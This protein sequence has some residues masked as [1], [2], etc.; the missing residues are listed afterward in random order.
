MRLPR[1]PAPFL[2]LGAFLFAGDLKGG[3]LLSRIPVDLTLLTGA[4]LAAVLA[5]RWM[6]GRSAAAAGPGPVLEALWYSTFLPGV[7]EAPDTPYAL[8]KMA[9]LF[10]FSLLALLAPL[11]LVRGEEDLAG[12]LDAMALFALALVLDGFLAAGEGWQ[13]LASAGG[14][15]ISLGRAAGFL[16]L[17]G[18]LGWGG[19]PWL[20]GVLVAALGAVAAFFSGSRGPMGGAVLALVLVLLAGRR[21]PVPERLRLTGRLGAVLLA[22]ALSLA[23]APAGSL[24]RTLAFLRGDL[25]A[26]GAYRSLAARAAWER[27]QGAPWGVGWGGFAVREDLDAGVPRQYPHDLLLEVT[28]ESGWVCGGATLV[29]VLAALGAAW[30]GTAGPGGRLL[31]AALVFCVVNALV[32]GDVND[33]RPLF[34]LLSASF[35]RWRPRC[36]P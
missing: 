11:L 15:T 6:R 14:G 30:A 21:W 22:L 4:I 34:A 16:F 27:L 19:R 10:T 29:V 33:N 3:D 28:L 8:R 9:T 20:A 1:I 35:G 25:G 36:A 7:L 12:L 24:G 23:L 18:M 26:S 31:F 17:Y 2:A 13:R 5:L 32:S